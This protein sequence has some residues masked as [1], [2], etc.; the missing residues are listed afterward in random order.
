MAE[1]AI[2][3]GPRAWALATTALLTYRNGRYRRC[4]RSSL[5]GWDYCRYIM[6]C[7]WGYM[8]GFLTEDE[9]W[10]RIMPAARTLQGGFGSWAELGQDYLV[11]REFWSREE[12]A[13]TGQMYRDIEKWLVRDP[14][15]PWKQFSVANGPRRG[16]TNGAEVI[17]CA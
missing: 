4:R 13:R 2:T 14:R 10:R 1:P 6:L 17:I 11:G 15:S 3:S 12:T 8:V 9:V 5:V 16:R 7:R